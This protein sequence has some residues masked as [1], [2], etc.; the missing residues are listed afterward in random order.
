MTAEVREPSVW[1]VNHDG[2]TSGVIV[3]DSGVSLFANSTTSGSLS[4]NPGTVYLIWREA[5]DV[6]RV[7]AKS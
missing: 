2:A 1:A 3:P 4:M 5:P 6:W 7:L